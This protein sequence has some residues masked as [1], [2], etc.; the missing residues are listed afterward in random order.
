MA[1]QFPMRVQAG[2][3]RDCVCQAVRPPTSGRARPTTDT[4]AQTFERA[5]LLGMG[6]EMTDQFGC[7]C[8]A[9]RITTRYPEGALWP[10]ARMMEQRSAPTASR[11][12][13]KT[14]QTARGEKAWRWRQSWPR[15]TSADHRGPRSATWRSPGPSWPNACM[16]LSTERSHTSRSTGRWGWSY[17]A[18]DRASAEVM[19]CASCGTAD[20]IAVGW[21]RDTYIALVLGGNKGYGFAWDG[22]P[23]RAWREKHC[24]NA[25]A[26]GTA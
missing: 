23:Q 2:N 17:Q 5:R 12:E 24:K 18:Q 14:S 6:N 1:T 4:S 10:L 19:A 21:G 26:D 7:Y 13:G 22:L 8:G 3:L 9:P 16:Y 15:I 25:R 20:A 11:S